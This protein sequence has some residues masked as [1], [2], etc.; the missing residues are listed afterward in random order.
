MI[1]ALYT[2]TTGVKNHILWLDVISNN[3]ANVA[4]IGFKKSRATFSDLLSQRLRIALKGTDVRGG[5]NPKEVGLGV[6][7][8]SIDVIH[9]QG[10]FEETGKLTD[11]A[12]EGRGFFILKDGISK[13]PYYTRAGGFDF[14]GEGKLVNPANGYLV[15]GWS[16]K[17]DEVE[18]RYYIDTS[19][20]I[21]DIKI[22]FE[23]I[24]PAKAT[25][26]VTIKG[27]LDSETPLAI[28]PL[29]I[30]TGLSLRSLSQVRDGDGTSIILSAPVTSAQNLAGWT[31][32]PDP[33]SR[34]TIN[35]YTSK[36]L[37]T[38]TT[39]YQLLD[40]INNSA[41]AGVQIQYNPE[42]DTFTIY[43]DIRLKGQPI[44]LG[45]LDV[46]KRGFFSSIHIPTGTHTTEIDHKIRFTRL[47]DPQ[48]PDRY[49]YRWEAVNPVDEEV[50]GMVESAAI[51][52]MGTGPSGTPRVSSQ[53]AQ[54]LDITRPFGEAGFDLL[55]SGYENTT[56]TI[57]SLSTGGTYTSK[58]LGE[59]SSV[60]EFIKEVNA[61]PNA[62]VT[63]RYDRAGDRFILTNDNPGS[64]L[65][66]TE[67]IAGRGFLTMAKFQRYADNTS[68]RAVF[69]TTTLPARGILLL[70]EDGLVIENYFDTDENANNV[71]DL[72]SEVPDSSDLWSHTTV[73]RGTGLDYMRLT[74]G[75]ER[76]SF[77]LTS[78]QTVIN[79]QRN[80]VDPSRIVITVNDVYQDPATYT[81]RDN[82]GPDGGDQIIFASPP[83]RDA[84]IEV[85]YVR[86]GMSALK[87]GDLFIPN[88][89]EGPQPITFSPNTWVGNYAGYN[90][91]TIPTMGIVEMIEDG[92][93]KTT[94][95]KSKDKYTY[96]I[97]TEVFDSV[98]TAH[99]LGFSF[100][101]LGTNLWLWTVKNPV[102]EGK[103]AGYG[104]L[105]FN[106][107]GGYNRYIS[108]VF[109]SP[110]D[111][112]T[113]DGDNGD[114]ELGRTIGYRGIYFDPPPLGYPADQNGAPPPEYGARIVKIQPNFDHLVQM[115][116][117]SDAN[118]YHQDGFGKGVLKEVTFNDMG[119]IIGNF[120]N[121]EQ[122]PLG[123][124][125]LATFTNPAG[126]ERVS[127]TMFRETANSGIPVIA[128]P[129]VG[130]NGIIVPQ[131]LE[132]SNVQL[133][134]EFIR[135]II[136]ERAFQANSRSITT[137]D[138]MLME[139][140]RLR[141]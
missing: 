137:T 65:S 130:K 28:D 49:Y 39:I 40:E 38:Y 34:I 48:H 131:N 30:T 60:E 109:Q 110:S 74:N 106:W 91:G 136:A 86:M 52:V 141:G 129:G 58:R 138:R 47:L 92:D 140:M 45:E 139:L 103:L 9:T 117:P 81:F 75:I 43:N 71:L 11:L 41:A 101:R 82:T 104:I 55:P 108:E 95:H 51:S 50:V 100:E 78:T 32:P 18:G 21:N 122:Q 79:L 14:D 69:N 20:P 7:N 93:P 19:I 17:F 102:E 135:M 105:A 35:Q 25:E 42:L 99:K 72:T 124:V 133:V 63:L 8:A 26:N 1:R 85:N 127:G 98:G 107:D 90:P 126:L 5:L 12:I 116:H 13:A 111:P 119:V 118:I 125:A 67:S 6:R 123:Q 70:D 36:P 113:F 89:N 44:E 22:D 88:G 132:M 97:S 80:D 66:V 77:V 64:S 112:D 87:P 128:A 27:D 73:G 68:N 134:D 59:Y 24:L 16:A 61:D 29:L 46:T 115:A 15:Q 57:Y 3:V 84:I 62:G 121:G 114:P 56:I 33:E 120:D 76:E 23:S 37:S 94:L 96:N 53:E 4:T 83:G 54:A 31:L 10:S 2:G